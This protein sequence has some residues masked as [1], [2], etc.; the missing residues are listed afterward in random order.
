MSTRSPGYR[1]VL[2]LVICSQFH[3]CVSWFVPRSNLG[4]RKVGAEL[5]SRAGNDDVGAPAACN[6]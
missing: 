3:V 6:A 5:A 4:R 1:G 2:F